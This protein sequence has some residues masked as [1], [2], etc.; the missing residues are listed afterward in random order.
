MR[1]WCCPSCQ[2]IYDGVKRCVLGWIHVNLNHKSISVN[3]ERLLRLE[4]EESQTEGKQLG[5][6]FIENMERLYLELADFS[7]E[8]IRTCVWWGMCPFR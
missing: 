4:I 3:M 6:T 2:L 1:P 8:P 5:I 7:G